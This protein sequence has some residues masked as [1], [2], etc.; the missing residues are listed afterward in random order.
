[1]A[2]NAW[3]LHINAIVADSSE[4][5]PG[6]KHREASFPL[7]LATAIG[8]SAFLVG[9]T[10]VLYF[11]F[12]HDRN[13]GRNGD[14]K[15]SGAE[16]KKKRRNSDDDNDNVGDWGRRIT[17]KS[18][19]RNMIKKE[20]EAEDASFDPPEH[21]QR[22]LYKEERRKASVRFLAMKKTLYENIEMY[23]PD[24]KTMLC[25][26]GTK[27]ANWYVRKELAVW[28]DIPGCH[29][30][31]RLLFEPKNSKNCKKNQKKI[32]RIKDASAETV[33]N[34]EKLRQYNCTHKLNI[35]V[36]C[37]AKD[38]SESNSYSNS[39]ANDDNEPENNEYNTTGLM[40]HYVVPYVYR[41]LLPAKFK[42][43]LPHDVVLLCLD[44]HV[45][46][47]QATKARRTDLY[48]KLY[49]KDP[50]T[51][52]VV[53]IDQDLKRLKSYARA[54]WKHKDKLP[55][56]RIEQYESTI[57]EHLAQGGLEQACSSLAAAA[58]A[59]A[60]TTSVNNTSSGSCVGRIPED[61]LRE[62]ALKLEPERKNPKYISLADLVVE[63]LCQN[64]EAISK[65]V[66]GWRKFFVDTLR[67]RHLP[68]GWSVHSPVEV[69][70][71]PEEEIG[72][73]QAQTKE[74]D[75]HH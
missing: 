15:K 73:G 37:G 13:R 62:L 39:K 22:E 35:C 34:D 28:R 36:S 17:S 26:I 16:S 75:H 69:D 44:C 53:V 63:N 49:R 9:S 12:N 8:A 25:T 65:F 21:L 52:L 68:V 27:K 59:A 7:A 11:C 46:A 24:G 45:E 32:K 2:S 19:V 38:A 23:A 55:A 3:I 54:L 43:H 57:A 6:S 1:M 14:D 71:S 74:E 30:S 5:K 61:V 51:R 33:D 40:R 18:A 58:A 48:E 72:D 29:Q 50:S 20:D 64:D 4:G 41:K 67:P 47:E 56:Q 70:A 31:I 66:V 10:A 42:T 60:T